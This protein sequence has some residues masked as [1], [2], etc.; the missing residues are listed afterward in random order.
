[1]VERGWRNRPVALLDGMVLVYIT[2]RHL[3]YLLK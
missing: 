3:L 2:D 1:M